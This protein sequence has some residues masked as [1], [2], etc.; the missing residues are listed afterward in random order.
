MYDRDND[1]L[2]ESTDMKLFPE[3]G[4][5][6]LNKRTVLALW[7]AS[8]Y[9]NFCTGTKSSHIDFGY[10]ADFQASLDE[11][12]L[13]TYKNKLHLCNL[14]HDRR[15]DTYFSYDSFEKIKFL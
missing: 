2:F 10:K 15:T 4:E 3:R 6:I 7:F 1:L 11:T 13:E 9:F 5:S 14:K 8:N 12:T